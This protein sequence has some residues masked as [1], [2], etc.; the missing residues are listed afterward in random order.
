VTVQLVILV[1]SIGLADSLNPGTVGPAVFL[2]TARRPRL[3][4]LEF[5]LGVF[6]VNMAAGLL[7]A[8]GPGHLLLALLPRVGATVKHLIELIAGVAML[9]LAA[10]LLAHRNRLRNRRLTPP[11]DGGRSGLALGVAITA[12]ELPTAFPYFAAVAAIVASDANIFEEALLLALFNVAFLSPV[13]A[14]LLVLAIAGDHADEALGR[15]RRGFER[16]WPVA[17]A[18]LLIAAG[19]AAVAFGAYGLSRDHEPSSRG[20]SAPPGSMRWT[21]ATSC[22][23]PCLKPIRR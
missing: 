20:G 22:Q 10:V 21:Q 9:G 14:I 23:A 8:L 13:L 5:C 12:V 11:Q 16:Q 4:V 6:A 7:M 18:G 19:A 3:Q 2:A 17:V 1:I 15:F